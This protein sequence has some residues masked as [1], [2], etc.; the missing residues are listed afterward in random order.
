MAEPEMDTDL[1]DEAVLALMYP[2]LYSDDEP[3]ALQSSC[4]GQ[5]WTASTKAMSSSRSI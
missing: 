1:I 2:T 3:Y 4:S 5:Y